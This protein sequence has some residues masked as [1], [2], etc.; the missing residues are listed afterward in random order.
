MFN[1]SYGS[2]GFFL[3][4]FWRKN[5]VSLVHVRCTY[6]I[7]LL[8]QNARLLDRS[9]ALALATWWLAQQSSSVQGPLQ[10]PVSPISPQVVFQESFQGTPSTQSIGWVVYCWNIPP[11]ARLNLS[12]Y[13][14][15]TVRCKG[16][17]LS[18]ISFDPT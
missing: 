3:F 18:W 11:L 14:L 6:L 15:H 5:S 16:L 12:Y 8:T 4:V 13:L 7:V 17:Q 2:L 9:V 1:S 10:Q